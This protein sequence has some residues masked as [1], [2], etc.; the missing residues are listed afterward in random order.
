[1]KKA[2]IF[3]FDGL[4]ID[5]ESAW[6]EAYK[7]WLSENFNYKL[8]FELFLTCIG[9]T[10]FHFVDRVN[11]DL[12]VDIDYSRFNNEI[13]KIAD[14]LSTEL[15]L[16][17]GVKNILEFAKSKDI[18]C[19]IGTSSNREHLEYHLKRLEIEEYFVGFVTADD[20]ENI[21]PSPDIYVKASN[22]LGVHKKDIIIF[23][24][25]LNGLLAGNSAGI[26]VVVVTN[27]VTSYIEFPEIYL[28]K[29]SSF[30]SYDY[31]LLF[32]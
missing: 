11:K 21:K 29:V 18:P 4:I 20:V 19:V 3:D 5:T 16:R 1:M 12:G 22:I 15:P 10:N 30:A 31:T 28:E 6:F 2:I 8:D 23:E 24:D 27:D 14:S 7:K 13:D 17:P 26:D 25:S 32:K 9:T